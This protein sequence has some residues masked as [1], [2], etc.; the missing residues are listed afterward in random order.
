MILQV[1]GFKDVGKTTLMQKIVTHFKVLGYPVVT[2]KHHGHMGEDI[3][4]PAQHLDHMRHFNA[5]ADQSI[6]QGHQYIESIQRF[7][8]MP[9]RTLID[10]CVTI[11][12]SII[13]V[14][15]YKYEHYD[16]VIVYRNEIEYEQLQQ[17][18]NV[19][20]AVKRDITTSDERALFA[21]L[22]EW[23]QMNEG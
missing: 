5:G 21:W 20:F 13:L 3:T 15:G 8:E 2:I 1:V 10:E 16:K 7:D 17:L 12:K 19:K 22:T 6:V 14:E 18:S 4:L 9:L 11:E 23:I